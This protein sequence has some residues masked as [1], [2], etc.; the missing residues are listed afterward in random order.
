MQSI[1]PINSTLGGDTM[2]L[3]YLCLAFLLLLIMKIVIRISGNKK[4]NQLFHKIHKPLGVVLL[5]IS[6]L[7]A[8]VTLPVWNTRAAIVTITGFVTFF[9]CILTGVTY[10]IRRKYPKMWMKYHRICVVLVL[11]ALVGHMVTYFVDFGNYQERIQKIEMEGMT[12]KGVADG[13]YYGEYD[14]GYIKVSVKVTVDKGEMKIDLLRHENERG[15]KAEML[16]DEME[17][18]Q[19]T[20]VDAVS[21]ATNSSHVIIKAVENALS[22]GRERAE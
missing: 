21:G 3:G 16:I 7:H 12:A 22:K 9:L 4:L 2:I 15:K 8:I 1:A 14:A 11:L 6:G 19:T 10:C 17:Q 13:T 18:K 5:V 20:A